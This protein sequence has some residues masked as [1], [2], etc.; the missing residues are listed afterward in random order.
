MIITLWLLCGLLIANLN[1]GLGVVILMP[2]IPI[3]VVLCVVSLFTD[4]REMSIVL[5]IVLLI[6]TVFLIFPFF[7]FRNTIV[8][9]LSSLAIASYIII[10]A[11]FTLYGCYEGGRSVDEFIF[12][13]FPSPLHHLMRWVEFL[14]GVAL[15]VFIVYSTFILTGSRLVLIT[16]VVIISIL[17]LAGLAVIL[18]LTGKFNAWLGT[19]SLYAGIYF[20]YLVVAFLLAP[21]L[22]KE[23]EVYPRLITLIFAIFDIMILL[24]TIGVLVGER[25]ELLSKKIGI[26][27]DTILMWLIFSK[28][29]YELAKLLN[30]SL[31]SIKYWWVLMIFILLLGIVGFIGLL[32]YKKFRT[33]I[34]R[35]RTIRK[36]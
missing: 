34:R 24:Y 33:K 36:K 17:I 32:K 35:K 6:I 4:L 2:L 30:P 21:T 27:P 1:L 16:W 23:S 28:A 13:R 14:G 8:P 20:A 19:Y 7:I 9:F 29:A 11:I 26:K 22:A 3:C 18:L 25:A 5:F 12:T 15:G 31:L 10:T